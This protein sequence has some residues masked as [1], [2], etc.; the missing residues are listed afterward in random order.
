MK[1]KKTL[2][3]MTTAERMKDLGVRAV[4]T[5]V[6]AFVASLTIDYTTREAG[7]GAWRVL[8][9]SA[10]AAGISAV[11][12]FFLICLEDQGGD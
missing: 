2:A 3:E 9:L 12:N 7:L 8:L 11:M 1:R 4:K 10:T 6:Q 5:F